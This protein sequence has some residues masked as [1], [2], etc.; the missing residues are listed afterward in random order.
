[1]EDRALKW[2]LLRGQTKRWP[3]HIQVCITPSLCTSGTHSSALGLRHKENRRKKDKCSC[4]KSKQR[5]I[6]TAYL[7]LSA[8][9]C[10]LSRYKR[11]S[12]KQ[13]R[14]KNACKEKRQI[15][16]TCSSHQKAM[17]LSPCCRVAWFSAPSRI[18]ATL[19]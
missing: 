3:H 10:I 9:K 1:M 18:T 6:I 8:S 19:P 13:K 2:A 12:D 5:V 11:A 16:P 4:S 15:Q 14:F 17:R 7:T